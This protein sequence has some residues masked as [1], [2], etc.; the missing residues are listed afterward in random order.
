MLWSSTGLGDW[1]E[2]LSTIQ[3]V[4]W[5]KCNTPSFTCTTIANLPLFKPPANYATW[6]N[7]DLTK[8]ILASNWPWWYQ[9]FTQSLCD[10]W[11][12]SIRSNS[13]SNLRWR[14][15]LASDKDHIVHPQLILH[16]SEPEW[17]GLCSYVWKKKR[18]GPCISTCI[19]NIFKC[20]QQ[21][22]LCLKN[23]TQ[24]WQSRWYTC[25]Q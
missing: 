3:R 18:T 20:C 1:G 11:L 10:N 22:T 4:R 17:K 23:I 14:Y 6:T 8:G 13:K 12:T 15:F 16:L 2:P 25:I 19:K 5:F 9:N 7:Y 21:T 24:K